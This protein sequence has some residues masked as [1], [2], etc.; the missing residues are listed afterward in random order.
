[1]KTICVIPAYNE[2]KNIAQVIKGLENIVDEVIV[3]DDASRDDTVGQ[4]KLAGALATKF[5]INR[6]QGA[7]LRCGTQLAIERNADIIIHYDADGQFR[8]IDLPKLIAPLAS[9][10]ADMVFGSRFLDNSTQMPWLKKNVIMPLARLVNLTFGI[11]LTDPQSGLRAFTREAGLKL[12]WQQ[13]RMAH[14]TEI[15]WLAHHHKFKITEV[16]IT[17]IYNEFG[18]KLSGGFKIIVDLILAKLN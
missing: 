1:M 5:V 7:A 18:Q 15:L 13:D 6:G 12:N 14:C 8:A 10:Q 11:R 3:V 17:V 4:A 16:P 9:G 2:A